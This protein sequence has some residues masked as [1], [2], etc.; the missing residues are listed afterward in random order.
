MHVVIVGCGR[1]GGELTVNLAREGHTVSVVDKN[2]RAFERLPP[3]FEGQTLVGIGFDR[4][5]LEAAGI[6]DA[7]SFLAVT[8]GDNSNIVSARIA[9]EHYQVA[10]VMARINDPRRAEIYRRLGIPTVADVRWALTEIMTTLF[11]GVEQTELALGEGS[12]VMV[13]LDVPAALAGKPVSTLN[14]PAEALV[15]ALDRMGRCVIPTSG[16]TFQ[17]GDVVHVV[18]RRESIDRLRQRL[19]GVGH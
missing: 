13:R 1:L 18:I 15:T 4:E 9:R 7:G 3:G 11:H 10:K 19:A 16:A 5:T 12:M 17:E 14:E 8:N 6:R 2:P